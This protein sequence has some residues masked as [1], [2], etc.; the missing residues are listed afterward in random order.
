MNKNHN[1][2]SKSMGRETFNDTNKV[3]ILEP[4]YETTFNSK[5]QNR[6]EMF[7]N[8][9]YVQTMINLVLGF[10]EHLTQKIGLIQRDA[11]VERVSQR[12]IL[13]WI[14][15]KILKVLQFKNHKTESNY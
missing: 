15:D 4:Q 5:I 12:N 11:E 9:R 2:V 13:R 14:K 7:R 8:M 10:S 6:K 3:K 1:I